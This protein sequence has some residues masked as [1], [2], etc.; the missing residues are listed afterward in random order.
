V[1]EQVLEKY[2]QD[3]KLVFKNY[4]LPSIHRYAVKA[5]IAALAAQG[6]GKFWEFNDLL[7][8]NQKH[9]SDKKVEEIV[10]QLGLDSEACHKK[11]KDPAIRQQL[12]RDLRDGRQ[13]G[14]RGVPSVYVNGRKLKN[15]SLEGFEASIDKELAKRRRE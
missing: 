15:R 2:P 11:L 5:A 8:R 12:Q 4:P 7:F 3:V 14:V 6:Q 13:A 1:L 10:G 9:L